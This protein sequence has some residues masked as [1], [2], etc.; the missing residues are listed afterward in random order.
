MH[1]MGGGGIKGRL[2]HLDGQDEYKRQKESGQVQKIHLVGGRY[3]VHL[4]GTLCQIKAHAGQK[5]CRLI[6]HHLDKL[7][8][9]TYSRI[10]R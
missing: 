8:V 10:G 9:G 2:S 7:T 5:H 1:M 3:G 4:K 6:G